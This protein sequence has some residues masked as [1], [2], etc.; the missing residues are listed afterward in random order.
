M[1]IRLGINPIGWSNDD[2][3][4][5]GGAT[6]LERCLFEARAAGFAGIELGHK[7]PREAETLRAVLAR[8]SLALVSGWYSAR[9]LEREADVEMAAMRPHLELIRALGC[10]VLVLAETS[11]AIHSDQIIPLSQRPVLPDAGWQ[12]FTRRLTTLA[13]A[14]RAEG[15]TIAYHHHMGT[16]VQTEPEIDRLMA[17]TGDT[18]ALLVDTGHATFA[19]ADP[20][21][22]ARRYRGRV[23]HVH[24]KDIRSDVMARC[25]DADKS[26]LDSVIEGVFTVP[27]DGSVDFA[28]VL[29]ELAGYDGWLVV[30][31]EQDPEKANPLTYAQMGYAG[32]AKAA[33]AVFG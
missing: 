24:C 26:F 29:S 18:V 8:H 4:D 19:G 31:A 28:A 21:R 27:G 1:T 14:V 5:L 3:R 30:E 20:V 6:P 12:V 33:S 15:L 17:E 22:L 10:E 11:N 25:L 2:L 32:L 9:L 23:R 16:V 13:N 7:F